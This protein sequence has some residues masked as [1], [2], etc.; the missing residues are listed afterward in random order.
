MEP[1]EYRKQRDECHDLIRWFRDAMIDRLLARIG[2]KVPPWTEVKDDSE[3]FDRLAQDVED[4]GGVDD[5][6]DTVE[7]C[8]DIANRAAMIADLARLRIEGRER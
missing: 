3:L 4:L 1:K 7:L 2:E 6:P 8:V 5:D